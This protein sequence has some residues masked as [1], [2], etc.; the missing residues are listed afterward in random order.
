MERCEEMLKLNAT[1]TRVTFALFAISWFVG[2]YNGNLRDNYKY[3]FWIFSLVSGLMPLLYYA[4]GYKKDSKKVKWDTY[5]FFQISLVVVVFAVISICAIPFNGYHLFMW[6]DIF[7]IFM[8]AFYIFVIVNLDSSDNFDYYIHFIFWGFLLNFILIM[9]P[10][11]F[12]LENFLSLSFVESYSPWESSMSDVFFM[13]FVYYYARKK[14]IHSILAGVFN[15]MAFK[16]LNLIFMVVFIILNPFLKNKP[17]SKGVEFFVKTVFILS[18]VFVTIVLSDSF[19]IWFENQFGMDLNGF[20]MGRF[21]QLN[22]ICD[23]EQNMTGLGMTHYMLIQIGFDIHRLH[24]D[25]MRFLIETTIVGLFVFV[26]AYFNI[27]KRNQKS[28]FLMTSYFTVMVASTCIENTFYW[29][30]LLIIIES[31]QRLENRREEENNEKQAACR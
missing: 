28:F 23:L 22:Q 15:V 13:C 21:N 17:V 8:P 18:P 1:F 31:F 9:K 2:D 26:N 4:F 14:R 25:M 7:Y 10:S 12:T 27:A 24:C 16:R 5:T 20:T 11:S 19:A 30:L 6:K 3:I 29:F